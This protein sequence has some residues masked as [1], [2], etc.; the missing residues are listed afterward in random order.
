M[1]MPAE[2]IYTL[3]VPSFARGEVNVVSVKSKGKIGYCNTCFVSQEICAFCDTFFV[4][5]TQVH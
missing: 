5:S 1:Q 3:P 2:K 4:T